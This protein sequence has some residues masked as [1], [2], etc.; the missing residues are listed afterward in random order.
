MFT[1]FQDLN[2]NKIY[3]IINNKIDYNF[4]TMIIVI[5]LFIYY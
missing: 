4:E 1:C 3:L 5:E 2:Y